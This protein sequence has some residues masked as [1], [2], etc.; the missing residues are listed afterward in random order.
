MKNF[1]FHRNKSGQSKN[2]ME[3]VIVYVGMGDRS[4]GG[5]GSRKNCEYFIAIRSDDERLNSIETPVDISETVKSKLDDTERVSF[6]G[7]VK[8]WTC[9]FV[10]F[11]DKLSSAVEDQGLTGICFHIRY[12]NSSMTPSLSGFMTKWGIST[13]IREGKSVMERAPPSEWKTS[14]GVAPKHLSLWVEL[15]QLINKLREAGC[16]VKFEK[17]SESEPLM[18]EVM[19]EALGEFYDGKIA[20]K[21]AKSP[22]TDAGC[23]ALDMMRKMASTK[24]SPIAPRS[25]PVR[26]SASSSSSSP[27]PEGMEALDKWYAS[28]MDKLHAMEKALLREYLSKRDEILA[29]TG[30]SVSG[31]ASGSASGKVSSLFSASKKATEEHSPSDK[32]V[33]SSLFTPK[34]E[35][36]SIDH[37]ETVDQTE[38]VQLLSADDSQGADGNSSA[39]SFFDTP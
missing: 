19:K 25:S 35:V 37:E 24:S 10:Y 15:D 4:E 20:K 33:V 21:T 26:S 38:E 31:L 6:G 7:V 27:R 16:D 29:S 3:N 8:G 23:S 12:S 1:R 32:V 9:A 5:K 36:E 28:E 14:T 34:S 22:H 17:A 30:P 39:D 13:T 18:E 11:V 2:A